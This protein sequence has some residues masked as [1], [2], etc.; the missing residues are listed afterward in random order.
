MAYEA[1]EVRGSQEIFY[2]LLRYHA[3]CEED[4]R[5][6]Y[7]LYVENEGI[8]SLVKSQ[9]EIALSRVERYGDTVYLIP[10]EGNPYLGYTKTQL[11]TLLCRSGATDKDYYLSQFV[12]LT[13]LAEFYDGQGSSS[14]TRTF[15]RVGELQN[16]LS[17]RLKEGTEAM[18]EEDEKREG[19]AFSDMAEAYEALKSDENNKKYKTTKEGLIHNILLFLQRQGLITYVE[20]DETIFTT[21]KLDHFMDFNI[22]NENNYVRVARIFHELEQGRT[23]EAGEAKEQEEPGEKGEGNGI[24]Q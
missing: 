11:K 19:I 5:R 9:G 21:E 12:I 7:R 16:R 6:L 2:Y 8:Q 24:D 3:L 13:L 23:E 22:L 17:E 18:G 14:K 20:K 4:D 10:E 1:E 15:L